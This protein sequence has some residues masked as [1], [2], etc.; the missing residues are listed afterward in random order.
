MLATT[1]M[2]G[3]FLRKYKM[4]LTTIFVLLCLLTRSETL[5][6]S[7]HEAND[8]EQLGQNRND[9]GGANTR[10]TRIIQ[11]QL[12][13]K[14]FPRSLLDRKQLGLPHDETQSVACEC[15]V[16]ERYI[17]QRLDHFRPPRDTNS[18]TTTSFQQRYFVTHRYEVSPAKTNVALLCVGGEGPSLTPH[19]LVA[20]ASVHCNDMLQVAEHLFLK[21]GYNVHAY[22]LE[23]RYY[24][25]SYPAFIDGSSPVTNENLVYLSSKQALGDL[26][27]F[28]SFMNARNNY[29]SH[30]ITFGG[31]Y[32]GMLSAYAHAQFPHIIHAS[33]SSSAPVQITLNFA[34]YKEHVGTDLRDKQIGGS[35]QCSDI[36]QSGHEYIASQFL[37]VSANLEEIARIFGICDPSTVFDERANQ[38]LF[39]GEGVIDI[40]AQ[41]NDPACITNGDEDP[42]CNIQQL[43]EGLTGFFT[44]ST[45]FKPIHGIH[46]IDGYS[47]MMALAW[48]SRQQNGIDSNTTGNCELVDYQETLEYIRDPIRGK[49]EGLRSWLWQTCTEFGFYQTCERDSSCPFGRGFHNIS[50][51]LFLCQYAFGIPFSTVAENVQ[52]TLYYYGGREMRARRLFSVN[53][54][55]DPVGCKN[56]FCMSTL[57]S[58]SLFGLL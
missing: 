56:A 55:V 52:E 30:W 51:D 50:Q 5:A 20:N 46:N 45:S 14:Y 19:V 41:S 57:K 7:S 23:H 11:K 35:S 26:V 18:T 12:R 28:V 33:V 17:S 15:D 25:K 48:I 36:V 58:F 22:A 1:S 27:H 38:E 42:F 29:D 53:G 4:N 39:V 47:S 8:N 40:P 16:E 3:F 43:C 37:N 21:Y 2:P 6:S 13:K 54:D 31:S 9:I 34:K 24:G 44:N 49:E 32:P 10:N